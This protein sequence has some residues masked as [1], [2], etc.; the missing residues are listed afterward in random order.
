MPQ[1]RRKWGGEKLSDYFTRRLAEKR[2]VLK[3]DL[4]ESHQVRVL[5]RRGGGG[6]SLGGDFL[7]C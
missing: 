3:R 5:A 7:G 6:W 1:V 4:A 2:K